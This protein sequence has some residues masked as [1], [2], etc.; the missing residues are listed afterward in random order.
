M[1]DKELNKI[2]FSSKEAFKI[3]I[4]YKIKDLLCPLSDFKSISIISHFRKPKNLK[5]NNN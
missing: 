1:A 2:L 5:I 4:D 3:F